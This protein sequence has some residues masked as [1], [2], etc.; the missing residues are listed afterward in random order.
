MEWLTVFYASKKWRKMSEKYSFR[1]VSRKWLMTL[2]RPFFG[3][4]MG[5]ESS[6]FERWREDEEEETEVYNSF[7]QWVCFCISNFLGEDGVLK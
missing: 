5:M 6:Y 2:L 1:W 3:E 7:Q 4:V